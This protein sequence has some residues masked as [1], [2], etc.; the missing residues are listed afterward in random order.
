MTDTS[1]L[2]ELK[3]LILVKNGIHIVSPSDCRIISLAIQKELKKNVSETT[4]KRLFGFAQIKHDFSKFTIN[5]LKEYAGLV[6]DETITDHFANPALAALDHH[7]ALAE[8]ITAHTLQ[9]IRNR[10]S[11]PYELTIPREFAKHDLEF[12]YHSKYSYTAFISQPGYGKSILLSH[13]VQQLFLD[14]AAP[15]KKDIVVFINADEL[16]NEEMAELHLEDKIKSKLDI[17]TDIELAAFFEA[18]FQQTGTKLILIIDGFSELIST[19]SSKPRILDSLT[20]LISTIGQHEGIKL[21]LSMRSTTWSRFNEKIRNAYFYKQKWYPGSYFNLN[22]NSNVPPLTELEVEQ[23]FH[24]MSP[25]DFAKINENLKVQL[26]FPFHIQWYYQLK[27][28]YPAFESYTNI[29]FYEIISRFIQEKIYNATYATEKVLCCKK[30][31]QLTNYGRK[32]YAVPKIDLIQ[33]MPIIKD[34]YDELLADGIL[35]EEKQLKNGLSAEYVRFIQTHTFEYFLFLELYDLFSNQMDSKFFE[36][37]NNEY[38]GNQVRFQL[39]QWSVRLMVKQYKFEEMEAVL[40]IKLNSYENN[41]LIYFIAENLSYNAKYDPLLTKEMSNQGLHAL[42]IKKLIHF[43]FIDSCYKDAINCLIDIVDNEYNALFYHTILGIFD[44]LSLDQERI[45]ARL[46]QMEVLENARKTWTIDPYRIVALIQ[47]KISGKAILDDPTLALIEE[48]KNH[49]SVLI[50]ENKDL[51]STMKTINYLLILMVNLFYGTPKEVIKIV[52]AIVK[53]YPAL[54]RTREFFSIYLLNILAQAH[55]KINPG[56]KTDQMEKLLTNLYAD[57]RNNYTS[58]TQSVIL[59]IKAEQSKNRKDYETA[60][61]YA[62]ESLAIYRRNEFAIHELY[63]YQFMIALYKLLKN[64]EKIDFY[65]KQKQ[66]LLA[67]KKVDLPWLE[68]PLVQ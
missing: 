26:K 30:I 33:E 2:Q 19:R 1:I 23:I 44:C 67:K 34:A 21:V 4:I 53:A 14:P 9:N 20:G 35:M 38:T 51:P 5:T 55:A 48:F 12:F 65:T 43:D 13:L 59:S 8:K 7:R 57:I 56:A 39:L 36:L 64:Q 66:Q 24:K 17:Q 28:E 42:L 37:I 6:A 25:L 52:N 68:E 63:T 45:N 18:Q 47:Q 31:V 61:K 54:K 27:E 58:Y 46:K 62:E 3:R 40:S 32:G 29:L 22:D 49:G 11:V 50:K 41:Y 16:F 60:L 10:C 15:L